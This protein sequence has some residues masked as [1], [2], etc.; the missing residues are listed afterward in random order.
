LFLPFESR[1]ALFDLGNSADEK[2][3][4]LKISSSIETELFRQ[5]KYLDWCQIK[6]IVEEN[7][8]TSIYLLVLLKISSLIVILVQ[9][10]LLATCRPS[11]SF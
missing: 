10:L 8:D 5:A 11:T 9:P 4:R 7:M 6:K 1:V 2:I 3:A